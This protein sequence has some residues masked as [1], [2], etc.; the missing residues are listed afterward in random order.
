MKVAV[1]INLLDITAETTCIRNQYVQSIDGQNW[2]IWNCKEK[3][4]PIYVFIFFSRLVLLA[5]ERKIWSFN[6]GARIV[7]PWYRP[8]KIPIWNWSLSLLHSLSPTIA[9]N[10]CAQ[11]RACISVNAFFAKL[12]LECRI[13]SCSRYNKYLILN[14]VSFSFNFFL[15]GDWQKHFRKHV[16][17]RLFISIHIWRKKTGNISSFAIQDERYA[18]K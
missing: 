12:S 18:M 4:R 16:S 11:V 15:F 13:E 8:K 3:V 7:A 17:E 5:R 2:Y 1:C 9:L 14:S 10:P 6:F